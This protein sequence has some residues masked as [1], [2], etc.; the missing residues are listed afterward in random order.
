MTTIQ[1]GTASLTRTDTAYRLLG[2]AASATLTRRRVRDTQ[3]IYVG[4]IELPLRVVLNDASG[5]DRR[6][7]WFWVLAEASVEFACLTDAGRSLLAQW[8]HELFGATT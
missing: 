8:D 5:L 6:G 1:R 7:M 2:A 4:E 3:A